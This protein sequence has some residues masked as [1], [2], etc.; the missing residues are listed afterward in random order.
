MT[1]IKPSLFILLVALTLG[2]IWDLLFYGKPLGVSVFLFV[3]L[4]I[5]ALF[6]LGRIKGMRPVWRNLWL[7]IPLLFF[8][9]MVFIRANPFLTFL[10]LVACLASLALF[11]YFYAAGWV[12]RL[13]LIGY[14]M[15][16]LKVAGNALVQPASLLSDSVD[17]EAARE[18]GNRN[19]LPVARGCLFALP[20]LLV[21]GC[22][23]A[24]ADLV[25]A[26]YVGDFLHLKF[27]SDLLERL[28]RGFIILVIAWIV[29]G[30]LAYAL[31]RRHPP[32]DEGTLEKALGI[33]SRVVGPGFVEVAILLTSVNLLFLLFVWI[34]F[35]YLF[36]G[37][38]NISAEG[39]AYA[40]YARRGF[41]ELLT[42][43]IL[44]QGMILGLHQIGRREKDWQRHIFNALSSLMV[45][46]VL[47]ILASAF[48]RLLLYEA[49]FGYTQL[50]LYSHVFMVWL[51]FAFIWFLGTLWFRPNRFAIGAFVTSLG[52]LVTLN[53]INPDAFIAK[54]NLARYETTGKLD[55]YYLTQLS[56]DA[57]PILVWKVGQITGEEQRILTDHLY[58]RLDRREMQY[59]WR[60][61]PT[62]HFSRLRAYKLLVESQR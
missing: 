37:Q 57:V 2:L 27:L 54:Q 22:F 49:A 43:S 13:G 16:P 30:G 34:Q 59:N 44:A 6:T 18:R 55:A 53:V 8:A 11:A 3:L 40:E 4:L 42:V 32:D 15:V 56:D 14:A 58:S 23:L 1:R 29:A 25:F 21:F 61:W 51:G 38:A 41:F 9:A 5:A 33:V 50:R 47:I 39:Y 52:F 35:V 26:K 62:F 7:L 24:S 31:N 60:R 48:Q 17:L 45:G 36:G 20:V 12:E 19:L 46:L 10:N 28:W